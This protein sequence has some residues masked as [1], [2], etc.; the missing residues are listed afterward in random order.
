M[1]H[2][3]HCSFAMDRKVAGEPASA[4]G[5]FRSQCCGYLITLTEGE[6][7]PRCRWCDGASEWRA[8]AADA[9][10]SSPRPSAG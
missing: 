7:L 4:S 10:R 3:V 2:C 8:Q 1:A 9:A 5:K 6:R